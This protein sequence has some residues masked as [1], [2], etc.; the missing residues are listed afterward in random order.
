[1]MPDEVRHKWVRLDKVVTEVLLEINKE[2]YLPVIQADGTVIVR[3]NKLMYGYVEAAY[4]WYQ[5]IA[6]VSVDNGWT[7]C[8]KDRVR[9]DGCVWANGGQYFLGAARHEGW[10]QEHIE[11]LRKAFNE[12]T[13]TSGDELGIVGMQFKMDHDIKN[14]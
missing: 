14:V 8:M 7:K 1:M 9:K 4:Y 11:M 6:K 3:N 12:I 13:V 2:H 5:T 10:I